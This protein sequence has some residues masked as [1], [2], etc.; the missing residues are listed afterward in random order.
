M[1]TTV[2]NTFT[3]TADECR[4]FYS[5]ADTLR[6]HMKQVHNEDVTQK[7]ALFLCPVSDCLQSYIHAI[8]LMK[9]L[10]VHNLDVG[11][12]QKNLSFLKC[13]LNTSI[14]NR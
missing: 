10:K 3:C 5:R 9:H 2:A 13:C 6:L 11:K 4:R 12:L 14:S 7:K 8:Q 1:P